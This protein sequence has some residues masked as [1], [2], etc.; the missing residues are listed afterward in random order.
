MHLLPVEVCGALWKAVEDCQ[1]SPVSSTLLHSIQTLIALEAL[2]RSPPRRCS[3]S[4]IVRHSGSRGSLTVEN[5][6]E[7]W[8]DNTRGM[9]KY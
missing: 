5:H 8:L 7:L 3:H 2:T 1:H 4:G 6:L 9:D